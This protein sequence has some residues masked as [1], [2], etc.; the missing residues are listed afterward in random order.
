[1]KAIAK[2]GCGVFLYM[3][4]EGRGIGFHNKIRAYALQDEGLDTVEA[5]LS[6]GFPVDLRDYGVGAQIIKD[7]GIT[8]IR[9]LTNNPKKVI[10]LEGHGLEVIETVPIVVKPNPHNRRYLETKQEKMGH[11]LD[12]PKLGEKQK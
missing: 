2:A 5:N 12:L 10:S 11:T 4:Q 8:K 3:R 6:L 1:M 7:L 9:L